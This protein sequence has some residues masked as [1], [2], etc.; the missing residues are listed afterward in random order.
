MS[1]EEFAKYIG[2]DRT[3]MSRLESRKK[4]L[5]LET[6]SKICV[7][8]GITLKDFFDFNALKSKLIKNLCIVKFWL[9]I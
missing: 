7:G 8:L 2:V 9:I 3:Y 4:N 5:T 1:Q 6:L